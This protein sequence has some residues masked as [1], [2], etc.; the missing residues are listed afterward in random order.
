[1]DKKTIL[2]VDD[3]AENIDLLVGLLK[4]QFVVKAARNGQV[5]LKIVQSGNPPDLLLLDIIMP[6]MD[7]F[8]V[9]REIKG[10]EATAA[11][12]VIFMSSEIEEQERRRGDELGA[13]AYLKKPIEPSLLMAA[14]EKALAV[15]E[16]GKR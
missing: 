15:K 14:I 9:C 11:T 5:A 2:V 10:D 6:E 16:E 7:G 3:T 1:M 4:G 13:S 12:P 8:E